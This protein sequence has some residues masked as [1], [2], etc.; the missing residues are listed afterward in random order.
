MRTTPTVSL[1]KSS[2]LGVPAEG[3]RRGF[4]LLITITLLAFLV[5]LLVSLAALTRV[6]TQVADNNQQ[7]AQARQN[8]LMALNIA[9]GQLQKAAGPDQR[10]TGTADLASVDANG[11]RLPNDGTL[12][13]ASVG[14]KKYWDTTPAKVSN[15]LSAIRPGTRYW[16]GVWGNADLSTP[17]AGNGNIYEKTPRPVLLNWLVSGNESATFTAVTGQITAANGTFGAGSVAPLYS[18][19]KVL[20]S[21][22]I[23]SSSKATDALAYSASVGAVLLVGPGTAGTSARTVPYAEPAEDRYVVAPLVNINAPAGSVPGLGATAAPTIGRYA[24]WVGDE[25]VKARL[26]LND[27]YANYGATAGTAAVNLTTSTGTMTTTDGALARARLQAAPRTG[28]EVVSDFTANPALS[29][30]YAGWSQSTAASPALKNVLSLPQ[31]RLLDATNIVF[32]EAGASHVRLAQHIHDFSTTSVGIQADSYNGGLRKDL[33]YYLEQGALPAWTGTNGQSA[34]AANGILPVDYSPT[35][36]TLTT[37]DRRVPRWDL[38]SS[39]YQLPAASG[40]TLTGGAGDV[41]EIRPE[42]DTQMG[43][44][45]VVV[46]MR[47][48]IG[49]T[50]NSAATEN[51]NVSPA[52]PAKTYRM[53]VTPLIVL[54]NPYAFKLNAS[55]GIDFRFHDDTRITGGT[56]NAFQFGPSSRKQTVF[57]GGGPLDGTTFHIPAFTLDPG[58]AAVFFVQGQQLSSSGAS[59]PLVRL[60]GSGLPPNPADTYTDFVYRD[61]S[62]FTAPGNV[63]FRPWETGGNSAFSAEFTV[64]GDTKILQMISTIDPNRNPS[65]YKSRN[66]DTANPVNTAFAI[67]QW[68]YA[69]PGDVSPSPYSVSSGEANLYQRSLIDGNPRAGYYRTTHH[70]YSPPP[71]VQYWMPNT[72]TPEL[73]LQDFRSNIATAYWGRGTE[74]DRTVSKSILFDAPRRSGVLPAILSIGALQHANLAAEDIPSSSATDQAFSGY[75]NFTW[76]FGTNT[77]PAL[78][79][80]NPGHQPAYIVGNSYAPIDLFRQNARLVPPTGS[81]LQDNWGSS[82]NGESSGVGAGAK[83]QIPRPYYDMSY[84]LNATLWDGYFFSGIP[85]SQSNYDP[86]NPRYTLR[87]GVAGL[88]ATA[89]RN[90]DRAAGYTETLGALNINSTSVD[91]WAALLGGMK[92]LPNIPGLSASGSNGATVYPRSL[93]QNTAAQSTPTGTGDDSYGGYRQLGDTEITALAQEIVRQIRMRGPF[94][95]LGQFINR[96]LVSAS[97]DAAKG[98]GQMGALQMAIDASGLN[99]YYSAPTDKTKFS[100]FTSAADKVA[101]PAGSDDSAVTEAGNCGTYRMYADGVNAGIPVQHQRSTGIPGWLTQAD[102]LQAIGPVLSARSDTF[103]IRTYGDVM[104]SVT[105]SS[106]PVA[107]A[108]C[109]AVV[110]RTPDYIDQNDGNLAVLGNATSPAG[111]NTANQTFGRRLKVVSFRWLGPDDI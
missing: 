1:Q 109:E 55:A 13:D 72:G 36:Q 3:R 90:G 67:Y 99:A 6:E 26:N 77:S 47:L 104:N 98:V 43:I 27:P 14:D 80:P 24:W 103:V 12:P 100:A 2:G 56:G 4:A 68:R 39:F 58:E 88:S 34:G 84:L 53:L 23:T 64:S 51:T 93:W 52:I 92:N 16:T 19:A 97:T 82:V 81:T 32:D 102:V 66:L 38:L 41:V 9:L 86:V 83:S 107:R 59:I 62:G 25:G 61:Y 40:N 78:L 22:A 85:Q 54:A 105:G 20:S 48:M 28:A 96:V 31:A 70:G 42:T 110:Q 73:V 18:P 45:P 5:L 44:T 108:W 75:T 49:A 35:M 29:T 60:T 71:Y 37:S 33:T 15:G 21:G 46:K 30:S 11:N 106:T 76:M 8:A 17:T 89:V 69:M 79:P 7:L 91:A 101:I 111:T 50:A 87:R 74:N 10:V 57:S 65:G 94:V 95:S 63:Q